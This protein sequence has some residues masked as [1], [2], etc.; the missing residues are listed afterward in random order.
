MYL[1]TNLSCLGW[2]SVKPQAIISL[3]NIS[4]HAD[5]SIPILTHQASRPWFI[6]NLTFAAIKSNY[7]KNH[8]NKS[9]MF[10]TLSIDLLC[11]LVFA[12]SFV[13]SIDSH[14]LS[15]FNRLLYVFWRL[16]GIRLLSSDFC[17]RKHSQVQIDFHR[18]TLCYK[19]VYLITAVFVK[20]WI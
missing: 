19:P 2:Y 1:I 3:F 7:H 10:V 8:L 5:F 17:C 13:W 9:R 6:H 4:V 15:L 20:I 16:Y 11:L 12:R 14:L 18:L